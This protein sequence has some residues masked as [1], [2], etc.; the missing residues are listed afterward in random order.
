MRKWSV[1]PT[2]LLCGACARVRY[3]RCGEVRF[4]SGGAI[5]DVVCM[6]AYMASSCVGLRCCS[7]AGKGRGGKGGGGIKDEVRLP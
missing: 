4:R 6:C 7:G 3:V 2:A 1:L 5:R